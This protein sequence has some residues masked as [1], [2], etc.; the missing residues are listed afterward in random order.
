M[1][2]LISLFVA[3]VIIAVSLTSCFGGITG[4]RSFLG[5]WDFVKIND[6]GNIY[7]SFEMED[8]GLS[9][10][11]EYYLMILE[12]GDAYMYDDG[13]MEYLSWVRTEEGLNINGLSGR[14][15]GDYL[16]VYD[17]ESGMEIYFQKTSS[18]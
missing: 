17:Y 4:K 10:F 13:D 5:K 9:A 15:E 11:G 12:D 6:G 1:K 2:K 7:Y 8:Y 18:N 14:F 16:I 3:V